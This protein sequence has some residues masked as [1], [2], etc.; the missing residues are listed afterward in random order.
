MLPFQA[1]DLSTV[2]QK[3]LAYPQ[4][5]ANGEL[6]TASGD[7]DMQGGH[8]KGFNSK[9]RQFVVGDKAKWLLN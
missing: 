6:Q 9:C 5:T 7:P 8:Q 4:Q 3:L 1:A 2:P